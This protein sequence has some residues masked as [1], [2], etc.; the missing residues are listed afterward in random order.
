[1][2][3]FLSALLQGFICGCFVPKLLLPD[4]LDRIAGYL[5]AHYMID[6]FSQIFLGNTPVHSV[7]IML[8]YT[9]AFMILTVL[10]EMKVNKNFGRR[11]NA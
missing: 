11:R 7:I 2:L 1:M 4:V 9:I 6:S 8:L 3:L 10:A 5:P